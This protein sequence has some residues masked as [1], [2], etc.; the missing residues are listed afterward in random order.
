MAEE[1]PPP[2]YIDDVT[3]HEKWSETTQVLF[4][5]PGTAKI[6]FCVY[7]WTTQVP[8]HIDRVSPVARVTLPLGM[9]KTLHEQLGGLLAAV[10]QQTQLAQ[11]TPPSSAKN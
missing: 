10:D 9:A 8:V 6:E 4:G 1:F 11:A 3:C 5:P 2:T 7:R